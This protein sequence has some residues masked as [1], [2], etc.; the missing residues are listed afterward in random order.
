M[1]THVAY[2]ALTA[3]ILSIMLIVT[4]YLSNRHRMH[5]DTDMENIT[6]MM[7]IAFFSNVADTLVSLFSGVQGTFITVLLLLSGSWLYFAN[8]CLGYQWLRFLTTHLHIPF[9]AR[10]E[11]FCRGLLCFACICLAV[12]LFF[13]FVFTTVDNVYRR[14]G[15]YWIFLAIAVFYITDSL[16]LYIRCQ[17]LVGILKF[18]P[19][20]VFLLPI[21][22]G[23]IIQVLFYDI[24]TIWSSVVIA[25]AGV[26][27]ALKNEIIFT[28][29]LT[30]LYNRL[31][32]EFLWQ[33]ILQ[34]KEIV[35]T[36]IMLDLNS[37][38]QI[39]DQYGHSAGDEALKIS[40]EIINGVFGEFGV[41][42]RYAGDEFVVLL[43]TSDEAFVNALIR[44]TH[45]AFENWNTEQRKPYRLSA[46]MGYAILDLGKLSVDEFM[47]RIDAEM[48]QNKLAYYRLNDRRKERE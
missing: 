2:S 36:G 6:R 3:N 31:Y 24:P 8:A 39:N 10:R 32:L 41:V 27:T 12:N 46:S 14:S 11:K 5:H 43:N 9:S 33:Q 18:F 23:I 15:G 38:K 16:Y 34:K 19:V 35:V 42:M 25:I 13:P 22:V 21:V 20:Q 37:F 30:G 45:T 26:M 17:N 40:A 29:R 48:Y 7:G 28:D 1:T 44:S 4:L 47:H